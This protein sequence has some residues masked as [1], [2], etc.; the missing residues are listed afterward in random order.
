MAMVRRVIS[1]LLLVCFLAPAQSGILKPRAKFLFN[2]DYNCFHYTDS[3]SVVEVGFAVY[4]GLV[5]LIPAQAGF[6]GAIDVRMSIRKA[7]NGELVSMD[8]VML[9]ID[10]VDTSGSELHTPRVGKSPFVLAPET[11]RLDVLAVDSVAPARVDSAMAYFEVKP[12]TRDVSTSDV[13]LCTSVAPSNDDSNPFYKNSYL[14]VSNPSRVFST[15]GSPV[16]YTYVELYN[17]KI[18]AIYNL[19]TQIVDGAGTVLRERNRLRQFTLKDG[20]DVTTLNITTVAGGKYRFVYTLSDTSG[21]MIAK[22][23]KPIYILNPST[24]TSPSGGAPTSVVLAG[25]S[26]EELQD[27]FEKVKYLLTPD[28]IKTFK[29][30]TTA[31]ARRRFLSKIW[32]EVESG[33]RAI[34]EMTRKS[35][36][37]RV[38]KADEKYRTMTKDGWKTDRGRVFILYGEPDEIERYPDSEGRKPFEVWKYRNIEGGVD[39]VFV[40]RWK[41]SNY[42]LVTSTK[43]GELQDPNWEALLH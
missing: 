5:S 7:G 18:G 13:E 16:V 19:K 41:N 1:L 2:I 36:L 11:Y 29:P 28:D 43:R 12:S 37:Q 34:A 6:H 14:V 10:L 15:V 32:S 22:T 33:A 23:E 24:Q 20:V 4:P 35:Y 30:L 39:F 40:D 42:E 21:N 17:V 31:D 26:A 27:E 38:A 3:S 8:R 9:P 25:L